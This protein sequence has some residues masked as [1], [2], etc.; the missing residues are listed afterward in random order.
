MCS[1]GLLMTKLHDCRPSPW[2]NRY[3]IQ[4]KHVSCHDAYGLV[5]VQDMAVAMAVVQH[6]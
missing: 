5:A 3:A 1:H 2:V 6:L 4:M